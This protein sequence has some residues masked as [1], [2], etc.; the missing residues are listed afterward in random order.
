MKTAIFTC[1]ILQLLTFGVIHA[2]TDTVKLLVS[3]ANAAAGK[4]ISAFGYNPQDDSIYVSAFGFNAMTPGNSLM[5]R[6]TNLNGTQVSTG[7]ISEAQ[8]RLLY[9]DGD[10][11]SSVNL[12]LPGSLLLNPKPIGN[13]PA[14]SFGIVTDAAT[15]STISETTTTVNVD[16]TKRVYSYNLLSSPSASITNLVSLRELNLA[17]SKLPTNTNSTIGRQPAWVG[18]GQSF[19]FSDS[20]TNAAGAGGLYKYSFTTDTTTQIAPNIG[21]TSEIAV[22]TNGSVDSIYFRG[23]IGS[24]NPATMTTIDNTNGIDYYTYNGS[25]ISAKTVL[26]TIDQLK[27]FFETTGTSTNPAIVSLTSDSDKNLY[28]GTTNN[29]GVYR[30]D[31]QG[32]IVKIM[33]DAERVSLGLG[34]TNK[35]TLRMQIRNT[36]YGPTSFALTQVLIADSNTDG[37]L[38][39]NAFKPGDFNRDN[40]LTA[41]DINLVR[42]IEINSGLPTSNL[43]TTRGVLMSANAANTT[44]TAADYKFDLNGNNVFDWKDLKVLQPFYD[45]GDGDVNLNGIVDFGDF[46]I[47]QNNF[48]ATG[49]TWLAGDLDGNDLVNFADFQILQNSFGYHSSVLTGASP[50]AFDQAQWNAFIAAV[51]EPSTYAALGCLTLVGLALRRRRVKIVANHAAVAA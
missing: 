36:T 43:L 1:A 48:G 28:F 38:A 7:L 2:Q 46:Q 25:T 4:S 9:T 30:V 18:D 23:G 44:F 27:D 37:I 8:M 33:S 51:P 3:G 29:P 19:Y 5:R 21:S 20:N 49:K 42:T 11:N 26:K 32:R 45:F 6:I 14:Y 16:V 40:Q 41:A 35:Q 17:A 22:I 10:A 50:A 39:I 13:I 12:T 34:G 31:P 47:L 24:F 15:V